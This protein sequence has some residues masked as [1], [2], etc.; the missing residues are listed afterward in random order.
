MT[1]L[2]DLFAFERSLF[3]PILRPSDVPGEDD[4]GAVDGSPFRFTD[5]AAKIVSC[6]QSLQGLF[7]MFDFP[8]D[9]GTAFDGPT[10]GTVI[11]ERLETVMADLA[12]GIFNS[13][14]EIE[15]VQC[16]I[17]LNTYINT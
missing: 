7:E 9:D 17:Y 2:V 8:V 14:R 6:A 13:E 5:G 3:S 15:A 1:C 10:V 4:A 12:G 16:D 11:A